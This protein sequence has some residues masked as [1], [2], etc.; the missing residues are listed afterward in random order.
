MIEPLPSLYESGSEYYGLLAD[1]VPNSGPADTVQGEVL[2]AA[3]RVT[4]E[5]SSSGCGNW[6]ADPTFFD[7][8]VAFLL[9]HLCDGTFNAETEA[10]GRKLLARL[11]TYGNCDY[12]L[13]SRDEM[14]AIDKQLGTINQLALA[15]CLRHPE[16]IPQQAAS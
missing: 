10:L 16:L 5:F 14:L 13:R 4:S 8:F 2:R 6:R 9:A 12:D 15:W 11:Q 1:L 3:L 7:G